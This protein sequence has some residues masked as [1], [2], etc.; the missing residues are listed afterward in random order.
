MKYTNLLSYPK[1]YVLAAEKSSYPPDP[2]RIG[3]TALIDSPMIR[4][5]IIEQWDNITQDVADKFEMMLG[6]A[7]H[8]FLAPFDV[9][10]GA[11]AGVKWEQVVQGLTLVGKDDAD[12][13]DEIDDHKLVKAFAVCNKV[14]Q[15]NLLKWEKQLQIYAWLRWKCEG[16]L[17]KEL[18]LIAYFKDW[19]SGDAQRQDDYPNKVETYTFKVADMAKIEDYINKRISLHLDKTY[20]CSDEE[21]WIRAEGCAVLEKGRKSALAATTSVAGKRVNMNE[22]QCLAY[23]TE[24]NLTSKFKS[25][26]ITIEKRMSQA[27]NCQEFCGARSVCPFAK[28]LNEKN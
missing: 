6:T 24:N 4:R 15:Q 16:V 9:Q 21:K 17:T 7:W 19:S 11:R 22:E 8:N 12:F 26:I 3:V 18:K 1:S 14:K 5:L 23:I 27:R 2:K 25:G 10:S 28:G 20:T 13:P